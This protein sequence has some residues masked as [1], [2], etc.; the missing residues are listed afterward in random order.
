M[1]IGCVSYSCSQKSKDSFE[2]KAEIKG[3][4]DGTLI[5]LNRRHE[6]KLV[7]LDS[8]VISNYSV[9]LN[10]EIASPEMV[11]LK[12]GDS[13]KAINL[14]VE[15][16]E[17]SV[18]SNID[19]LENTVVKGS[20]THDE[21]LE[22]KGNLDAL[23]D[24]RQDLIYAYE[25]A[26]K[27]NDTIK[28]KDLENDFNSLHEKQNDV[29]KLFVQNNPAS[30]ISPFAIS[31]YLAY[32]MDSES[33]DSLLQT[34]DPVVT[35]STYYKELSDRVSILRNVGIGQSAPDFTLNQPNQQPLTLSTLQGSYL[36]I[37][38]WASWCVPCRKENPHVVE[39]YHDFRDKG[40]EIL[41]VSLD[42]KN[43]SWLEAIEK[44]QLDWLHVSDL[45]GW[46]SEAGRLYGINSIP[47][48]VLIDPEG[49]I[50]AKGLR[51][52][53]LREKLETILL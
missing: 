50:I 30:S 29:V 49:K 53:E 31:S 48:T 39:V 41:G 42:T 27:D 2:I 9:S 47:H 37:D 12:I 36:L 13:N 23:S 25:A 45:K 14:F 51:A 43:E 17:I 24:E 22:L 15:P 7:T 40:F 33:L 44:D 1:L 4:E 21:F 19:S 28:I 26:T 10:G 35:K 46:Q 38:F 5:Y 16:G 3:I 8:A 6:G 18:I 52:K 11:L 34:L 32:E 20:K